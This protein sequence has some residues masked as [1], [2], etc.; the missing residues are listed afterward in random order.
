MEYFDTLVARCVIFCSRCESLYTLL[1]PISSVVQCV[2]A[3]SL[4]RLSSF[5]RV[6]A[7]RD[8]K[9]LLSLSRRYRR[10]DVSRVWV[11]LLEHLG[12]SSQGETEFRSVENIISGRTNSFTARPN[13][14][15][16]RASVRAAS[17]FKIVLTF[18]R[19][20]LW[21]ESIRGEASLRREKLI[22]PGR[23]IPEKGHPHLSPERRSANSAIAISGEW[24]GRFIKPN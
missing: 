9:C 12:G 19:A 6:C 23:L 22:L 14:G 3:T 7:R 21:W 18:G 5:S 15:Q 1:H 10:R 16:R 24:I 13:C 20:L 8:Y 2:V 11:I 4:I 17:N